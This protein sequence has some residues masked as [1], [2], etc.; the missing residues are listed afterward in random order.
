MY[1]VQSLTNDG[2]NKQTKC[3]LQGLEKKALER[4]VTVLVDAKFSGKIAGF[5]II[6]N[7][8]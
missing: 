2:Y 1:S 6:L 3:A 7:K 8:Y 4:E 5:L